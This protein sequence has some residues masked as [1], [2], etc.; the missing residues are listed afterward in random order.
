MHN[1]KKFHIFFFH[2]IVWQGPCWVSPH[3]WRILTPS[4]PCLGGDGGWG[5][6]SWPC[7]APFTS[8]LLFS[9]L[10][11]QIGMDQ[12]ISNGQIYK[13]K[14]K[15]VV[16]WTKFLYTKNKCIQFT[17][18]GGIKYKISHLRLSHSSQSLYVTP[19]TQG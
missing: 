13:Q 19:Q 16:Q 18:N 8:L 6:I 9:L 17:K 1:W 4:P 5:A 10:V 14:K 11:L 2:K 12:T 15:C 3:L 7:P